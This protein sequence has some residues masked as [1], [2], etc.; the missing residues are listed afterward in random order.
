MTSAYEWCVAYEYASPVEN[1]GPGRYRKESFR[2]WT[3]EGWEIQS[4]TPTGPVGTGGD[5][6]VCGVLKRARVA[7]QDE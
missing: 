6:S 1:Q 4:I 2:S 3:R 5:W 7:E